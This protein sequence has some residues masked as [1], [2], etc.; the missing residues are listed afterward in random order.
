MR[1]TIVFEKPITI[2]SNG[3]KIVIESIGGEV[4]YRGN[5]TQFRPD[6]RGLEGCIDLEVPEAE[7]LLITQA[8][9]S[10]TVK[11]R[12]AKDEAETIEDTTK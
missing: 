1:K 11:K 10:A 6:I 4:Q 8:I 9:E 2:D 7:E 3:T 5:R 12:V